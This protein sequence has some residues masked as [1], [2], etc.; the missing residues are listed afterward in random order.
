AVIERD[1]ERVAVDL[2]FLRALDLTPL[3]LLGLDAPASATAHQ[4]LLTDLLGGAG[5]SCV[6]LDATG[7]Y[8]E[9]ATAA[10]RGAIPLLVANGA[11]RGERVERLGA[12]LSAL[13]TH[14]LIFLHPHGGLTSHG[15]R[16]S[17]VN[18]STEYEALR[19]RS[20]LQAGQR[21]LLDDSRRL[22][23]DLV[24]HRLLVSLTSPLDLLHELFTVKGAGTLMRKG[25]VITRHDGYRN[26][27]LQRLR[28]LLQASFGKPANEALFG[29]PLEHAYL[30]EDYRGAALV[31]RCELGGYL[32][33]FAVTREAQ[34][35]GIGQDLWSALCAD[36]GSLL[37]RAK[38]DNPVRPWY[39]RQ[40]QGRFESGVWT[41]YFRGLR[42]SQ[43]SQAVEFAL[44]QPV[45]F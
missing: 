21:Q 43:I 3:V 37:W 30:E 33:K 36:Y 26:V 7:P 20:D 10:R 19:G 29:R 22:I 28:A 39:E 31:M 12:L 11:S 27:E 24:P 34:G 40:C 18:L 2:R 4:Q 44:S 41:V 15:E 38:R 13:H 16:L 9:I 6:A 35:E 1:A 32:S 17:V 23:F 14:K 8:A 45:D 5:V 42:P 25:A